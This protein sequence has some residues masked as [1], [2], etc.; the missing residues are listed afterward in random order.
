L[1]C[2]KFDEHSLEEKSDSE[3]TARK[4]EN[5]DTRRQGRQIRGI[6]K[7]NEK[8][9]KSRVNARLFFYRRPKEVRIWLEKQLVRY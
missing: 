8:S 6:E 3:S 9:E 1:A 2:G 5:D 4:V 7:Q